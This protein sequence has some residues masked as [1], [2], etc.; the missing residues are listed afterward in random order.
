MTIWLGIALAAMVFA[1]IGFTGSSADYTGLL[2]YFPPPAPSESNSPSTGDRGPSQTQLHL[3]Y[4]P[5]PLPNG[6]VSPP[7]TNVQP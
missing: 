6:S 3:I 7:Q 4:V 2:G 1:G 5:R